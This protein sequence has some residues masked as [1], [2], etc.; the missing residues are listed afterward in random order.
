MGLENAAVPRSEKRVMRS[1][2]RIAAPVPPSSSSD[3]RGRTFPVIG[4]DLVPD[5]GA[6][7]LPASV[8]LGLLVTATLS[9]N[10]DK[11]GCRWVVQVDLQPS[12][13]VALA[14]TWDAAIGA[15]VLN[16]SATPGFVEQGQAL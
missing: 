10:A 12:L 7:G 9:P 11:P 4:C 13:A 6:I 3:Q 1:F 14:G 5:R 8:G 2:E 15:A 16:G